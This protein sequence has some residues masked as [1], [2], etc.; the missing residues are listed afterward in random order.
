MSSIPISKVC[1]LKGSKK[2][3]SKCTST[4]KNYA[5]TF[6]RKFLQIQEKEE[7][8]TWLSTCK[9]ATGVPRDTLAFR[10]N[11]L[12]CPG[13]PS[14]GVWPDEDPQGKGGREVEDQPGFCREWGQHTRE[15]AWGGFLQRKP[16]MILECQSPERHTPSPLTWWLQS[17]SGIWPLSWF[18][19]VGA[20]ARCPCGL[21]PHC[22]PGWHGHF[23]GLIP[24][25]LVRAAQLTTNS[26]FL[27]L[28][29]AFPLSAKL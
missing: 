22:Q 18:L 1:G 4:C 16:Q 10:V 21:L 13:L 29:W 9:Q 8:S 7:H 25:R 6:L 5:T 20:R 17:P 11:D 26:L 2:S 28:Y 27:Y 19:Q 15:R 12:S 24:T 14:W 3:V 23:H